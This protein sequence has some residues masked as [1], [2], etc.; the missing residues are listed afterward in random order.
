V[1]WIE[2]T[3]TVEAHFRA[4]ISAAEVKASLEQARER[5]GVEHGVQ[6]G[7]I[8]DIPAERGLEAADTTLGFLK[9]HAPEGT[10]AFGLAGAEVGR[11]RD[12]FTDHFAAARDLGYPGVV[13]AG[14]TSGPETVWSALNDLRAV[15]IGHG[16]NAVK[17][18][19]LLAHLVASQTPVEVCVTSNICTNAV[20][21]FD[22][23]PVAT[24]L[25]H[26]VRVTPA[27][28]DP[29]MF[30]TTLNQE[31]QRIAQVAGMSDSDLVQL[32]RNS[33]SSSLAPHTLKTQWLGEV[34][35]AARAHDIS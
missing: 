31:Y 4:G 20:A 5:A 13:H 12:L 11:P 32:A 26:G 23:H 17:D 29:G 24:M 3:V 1:K 16:T 14:E 25:E 15:R 2:L 6:V 7:F 10:V 21:S 33:V 8:L 27:T 34:E 28:D 19:E 35:A 9:D 30:S 18:S 22:V